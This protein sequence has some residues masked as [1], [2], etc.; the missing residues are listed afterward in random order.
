MKLGS[1]S[2]NGPGAT[3]GTSAVGPG[4][5]ARVLSR[6]QLR[7]T[8]GAD[9]S[10]DRPAHVRAG[11]GCAFVDV[12]GVG[13]RLAVVQ[14][15]ARFIALVD[16]HGNRVECLD[17]PAGK[18]GVRQFDKLRGNK[19]D[20]LDLEAVCALTVDGSPALLAIGSGSAAPREVLVLTRFTKDGPVVEEL[21]AHA[22]FAR[23]HAARAFAGSELNVEGMAL[24]D[25]AHG[26]AHGGTLR[27]FNRGNGAADADGPAVDATCDLPLRALFAHL[28][29]PLTHA[30]PAPT[31]VVEHQLGAVDGTRLT[32]TD[33][34]ATP[35]GLLFL[36]AAEASPNAIDDGEVKGTAVGLLRPDGSRVLVPLLDERGRPLTDKV[37]GIAL[38]PAQPGKAYLVVDKDDPGAPAELLVVALPPLW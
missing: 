5:Q 17:L 16:A 36:A 30:A 38:D 31:N 4:A 11:S 32:F 25:E 2:A 14:D 20:K 19:M 18:G 28:R 34:T 3:R 26:G 24:I 12:P 13:R 6:R 8:D 37:E 1:R 15:D 29:D 22:L 9:A 33:A 27:L 35:H 23:L 21:P 7:Y 10:R